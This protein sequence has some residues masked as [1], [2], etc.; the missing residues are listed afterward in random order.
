[1]SIGDLGETFAD[2]ELIIRE[3]EVGNCMFVVQQGQV[4]VFVGAGSEEIPLNVLEPGAF[5]GEMALFDKDVRS[6][7]VRALGPARVL[8]VDRKNLL[9]R[10]HEDP[11]LAFRLVETMSNRIRR[12]TAK[13]IELERIL[14][15]NNIIADP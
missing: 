8:T 4:E 3:G 7:S 15:S 10:V 6:A 5:F 2:G 9:R 11:S 13:I 12:Q 14:D 1:M